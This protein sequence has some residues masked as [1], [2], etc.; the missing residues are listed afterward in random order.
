MYGS[1]GP[2]QFTPGMV[3]RAG[4]PATVELTF[5]NVG[6]LASS[7]NIEITYFDGEEIITEIIPITGEETSVLRNVGG[8]IID[9]LH[10]F[11]F[12]TLANAFVLERFPLTLAHIQ[13]R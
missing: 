13:R 9:S 5:V 4:K 1:D 7:F 6:A 2:V 3:T 10:Q 12:R 11:S 8:G